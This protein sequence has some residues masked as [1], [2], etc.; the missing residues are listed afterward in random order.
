MA[1]F[2]PVPSNYA[3]ELNPE[4][5]KRSLNFGSGGIPDFTSVNAGMVLTP[6]GRCAG[7]NRDYSRQWAQRITAE[8]QMHDSNCM[9]TFT[10]DDDHLPDNASLVPDHM[11]KLFKDLRNKG[12]K[13]SYYYCGEYGESTFRPHYHVAFFG[14]DFS[15]TFVRTSGSGFPLYSSSLLDAV[16][17]RGFTITNE[18]NSSTAA[19]IAN[20]VNKK[21]RGEFRGLAAADFD[22]IDSVL[23]DA[24][25]P[26]RSTASYNKFARKFLDSFQWR[27]PEFSRMSKRPAIGRRWFFKFYKDLYPSDQFVFPDGFVSKPARY[28]DKLLEEFYPDL[29]HSVKQKRYARMVERVNYNR[30]AD[31]E[32]HLTLTTN[33]RTIL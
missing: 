1:C 15:E 14:V 33:P 27:E 24:K 28:F 30:L 22:L 4:T 21:L 18:L 6:C 9:V 3:E 10:Y 29:F 7:C 5:G 8:A 12:F 31:R 13:F 2:R 26:N 32:T 25:R 23:A 11:T 17:A 19:Y 16:W 20:Y